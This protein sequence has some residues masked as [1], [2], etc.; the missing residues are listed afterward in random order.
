MKNQRM[1]IRRRGAAGAVPAA[2][3]AAGRGTGDVSVIGW[4]MVRTPVWA[5]WE[6]G[7]RWSGWNGW[8]GGGRGSAAGVSHGGEEV[9]CGLG[10]AREVALG[11][12]GLGDEA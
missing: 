6:F 7:A 3:V 10:D 11:A 8:S 5:G 2:A 1:R 4:A 9:L 12:T